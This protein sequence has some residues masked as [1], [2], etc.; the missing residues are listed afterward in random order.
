[1]ERNIFLYKEKKDGLSCFR[2]VC[3]Q[4]A[5]SSLLF[6]AIYPS[7]DNIFSSL[8]SNNLQFI[9]NTIHHLLWISWIETPSLKRFSVFRKVYT[10]CR[11]CFRRLTLSTQISPQQTQLHNVTNSQTRQNNSDMQYTAIIFNSSKCSVVYILIAV[12][13]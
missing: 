8:Q 2:E 7:K 9:A 4:A 6:N 10:V 12:N 13:N 5:A 3:R 11:I 1:M